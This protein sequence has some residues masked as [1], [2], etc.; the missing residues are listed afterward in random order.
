MSGQNDWFLSPDGSNAPL[1]S[2]ESQQTLVWTQPIGL[3][4]HR[5]ALSAAAPTPPRPAQT[6]SFQV[7]P[8]CQP[9][10]TP[11]TPQLESQGQGSS[12][13]PVLPG[14]NRLLVN[15]HIQILHIAIQYGN[16]YRHGTLKMFWARVAKEF[17][18]NTGKQ[19]KTLQQAVDR[20][21]KDR[22]EALEKDKSGENDFESSY[23]MAINE[24]ISIV[25]NHKAVL[26]ARKDAA[27]Q[28]DQD[29]ANADWWQQEQMLL[30]V[31][32]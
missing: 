14:T 7:H 11:A 31:N 23:S 21:V 9:T 25:D 16:A 13:G 19:H 12:T 20:L 6:A 18:K 15:D 32:K 1:P 3:Q 28:I 29:A 24:W 17:E 5:G 26:K 22:W 30:W 4:S 10:T 8:S 27:G 2:I